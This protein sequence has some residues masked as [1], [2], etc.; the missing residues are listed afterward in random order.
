V[1]TKL[2]KMRLTSVDLVRAGA[3]QKADIC[4]YKSDDAPGAAE[5]PT[6]AEKGLFRRFLTWL[7]S[8]TPEAD[9]EAEKSEEEEETAEKADDPLDKADLYKSAITDS[10]NSIASDWRLSQAERESA[11]EK[12]LQQYHDAM[13]DLLL[14]K[15]Q[16]EYIEDPSFDFDT[17][18]EI[19]EI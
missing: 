19:E 12:S 7:Q 5:E 10:I 18:D 11:I 14:S 15:A 9:R 16:E 1:A 6:Q 17:I 2:K 3:N 4:L 8:E 13:M